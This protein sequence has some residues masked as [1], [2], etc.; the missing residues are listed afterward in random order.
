MRKMWKCF[1]LIVILGII[2]ATNQTQELSAQQGKAKFGIGIRLNVENPE[3][4]NVPYGQ[5]LIFGEETDLDGNSYW[6]IT[7]H[8]WLTLP[9]PPNTNGNGAC[10]YRVVVKDVYNTSLQEHAI[11]YSGAWVAGG[12]WTD[13][14]EIWW[15]GTFLTAWNGIPYYSLP[16]GPYEVIFALETTI[17]DQGWV[18]RARVTVG[19]DW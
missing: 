19:L 8:G 7:A 16:A 4:P 2:A 10:A 11:G 1:G 17:P 5:P 15:S 13:S 3:N 14:G 6:G 18:E 9:L 12:Y